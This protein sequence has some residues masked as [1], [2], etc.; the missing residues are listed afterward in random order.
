MYF[1]FSPLNKILC[2][3]G[4]RLYELVIDSLKE[5]TS[6]LS[7]VF[8]ELKV[9][10]KLENYSVKLKNKGRKLYDHFS[11][12]ICKKFLTIHE[13]ILRKLWIEGTSSNHLSASL[14]IYKQYN[15]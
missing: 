6:W 3:I 14:K 1:F 10:V 12:C 2:R 11:R 15:T 4:S 9:D 8:K 5:N 7:D 13:K